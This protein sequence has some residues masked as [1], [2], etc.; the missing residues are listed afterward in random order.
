MAS[1]WGDYTLRGGL[2]DGFGFG[3]GVRYRGS[4]FGDVANTLKV[5][6]VTLADAALWYE[7]KSVRLGLNVHNI[8]DEEHVAACFVRAVPLC[9]LGARRT[10]TGSIAYRW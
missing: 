10:V 1:I 9:S 5:P 2:L 7:R 6:S 3:A 8:S 4:T